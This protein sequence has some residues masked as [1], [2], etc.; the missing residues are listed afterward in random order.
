[1]NILKNR[2]LQSPNMSIENLYPILI[3]ESLILRDAGDAPEKR[4]QL[5]EPI[6]KPT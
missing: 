5:I 6:L 1:M 2:F 3:M 4:T